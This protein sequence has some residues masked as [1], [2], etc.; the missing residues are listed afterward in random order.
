[1][2]LRR[3]VTVAAAALLALGL[4]AGCH[5]NQ[6]IDNCRSVNTTLEDNFPGT[7]FS[8]VN[9]YNVYTQG[10]WF[11]R[12]RHHDYLR[13]ITLCTW[14]RHSDHAWGTFDC[15]DPVAATQQ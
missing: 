15:S 4:A 11:S 12:C 9:W 10:A 7:D 8:L 14:I 6:A 2:G 13:G 3:L 1:M 5:S